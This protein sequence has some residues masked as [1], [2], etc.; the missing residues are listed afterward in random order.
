MEFE[1]WI[2]TTLG[3]LLEFTNCK[4]APVQAAALAL[5]SQLELQAQGLYNLIRQEWQ[6]QKEEAQF[7]TKVATLRKPME[8]SVYDCCEYLRAVFVLF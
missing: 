1:S 8:S 3:R 4:D 5:R 7:Q 2:T 6:R